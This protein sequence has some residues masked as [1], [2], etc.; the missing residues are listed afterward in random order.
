MKAKVGRGAD[1]QGIVGYALQSKKRPEIVGCNVAATSTSPAALVSALNSTRHLQPGLKNHLFSGSL[2]LPAGERLDSETWHNLGRDYLKGMGYNPDNIPYVLIRH[3][4]NGHDHIHVLHSLID[5]D[6]Q[7]LDSRNHLQRS[8]KLTPQLEEKYGLQRTISKAEFDARPDLQDK[9][10]RY[11]S[12]GER[13]RAIRENRP[14]PREY[15]ASCLQAFLD[16]PAAVSFTVSDLTAY[17]MDCGIKTRA[18]IA[19]GTGKLNG[20][21]FSYDGWN[22]KASQIGRAFSIKNL[23]KK[24]LY[25]DPIPTITIPDKAPA[26]SSAP[27]AASRDMAETTRPAAEGTAK[28]LATARRSPA[29][30]QETAPSPASTSKKPPA[31]GSGK[32]FGK[33]DQH[34][35]PEDQHGG[36]IVMVHRSGLGHTP[37]RSDHHVHQIEIATLQEE[38]RNWLKTAENTLRNWRPLSGA[39]SIETARDIERRFEEIEAEERPEKQYN[40]FSEDERIFLSTISQMLEISSGVA[41]LAERQIHGSKEEINELSKN[42]YVPFMH[43][44]SLK[45]NK[46]RSS[47]SPITNRIADLSAKIFMNIYRNM[48]QLVK[49]LE[50]PEKTNEITRRERSPSGP[51]F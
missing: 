50:R 34:G 43:H 23:M 28:T 27:A 22:G 1:W 30:D 47:F 51:E 13:G 4:D 14:V 11:V 17:L 46:Y 26:P 16:S 40:P 10:R 24:G 38:A 49:K 6:G 44:E 41:R 48:R 7:K 5:Y 32:V 9:H 20:F 2:S 25:Y 12:D 36:E 15:I 29:P 8:M 33:E 35:G 21:S 37:S 39:V 18:N 31:F 45:N 3:N 19:S 42:S